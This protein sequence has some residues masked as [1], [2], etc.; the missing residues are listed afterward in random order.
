LVTRRDVI[1][2]IKLLKAGSAGGV[3]GIS[4][5]FFKTFPEQLSIRIPLQIIF[6]ASFQEGALPEERKKAIVSP[7]YKGSKHKSTDPASYIF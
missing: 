2:S 5:W 3:D 1:D 4:A 7:I 6:E